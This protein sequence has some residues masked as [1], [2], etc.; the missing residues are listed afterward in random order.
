MEIR[1]SPVA[2]SDLKEIKEYQRRNPQNCLCKRLLSIMM[3]EFLWFAMK[4]LYP[5][6]IVLDDIKKN[7]LSLKDIRIKNIN[8]TQGN[9]FKVCIVKYLKWCFRNPI[10]YIIFCKIYKLM[11]K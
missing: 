11:E 1:L 6:N 4:S 3:A 2:V 5:S 9:R 7:K 10:I 8:D